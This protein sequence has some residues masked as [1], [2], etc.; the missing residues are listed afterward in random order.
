MKKWI[1]GLVKK[2]LTDPSTKG[3]TDSIFIEG[4]QI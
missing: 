1:L 2:H 4:G 3:A